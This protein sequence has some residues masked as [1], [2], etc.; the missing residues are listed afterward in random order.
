MPEAAPRKTVLPDHAIVLVFLRAG[1]GLR[2]AELCRAARVFP[3]EVNEYERGHRTLT[4]ERLNRL[5]DA[6]GLPPE[7]V[8]ASLEC[9]AGNRAAS[10]PP[11]DSP[12]TSATLRREIEAVATRAGRLEKDHVRAL[13]TLLAV[14]DNGLAAH[15]HAPP[16]EPQAARR[17]TVL[18]D[19]AI[20]LVFLRTGKGWSQ[21]EL[22]RAAQLF[23]S[24]ISEYESGSRTLIRERLDHLAGA[25]GLPPE[26]VDE[27]LDCLAVNR[28]LS[29]PTESPPGP[30]AALRRRIEALAT[31]AGRLEKDHVRARSIY[32]TVQAEALVA[33]QHAELRMARLRTSTAAQRRLLVE[34]DA[35]SR[36]WAL[37]EAAALESV[38]LAP[39]HPLQ[40]REWAEW[41][42]RIAELVPGEEPCRWR[43]Q[44][45]TLHFLSNALRACNDLPAAESAL[46]RGRP[47]WE[48][49][50]PG[51]PGMI[52]NAAWPPWIEANL[53]RDQRRFP[54]ALQ[55][56]DE[57][58][59]LDKGELIQYPPA[60]G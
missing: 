20:V 40:A 46:A 53:R 30:R 49:G 31:K 9:L 32:L 12:G 21:M 33:R 11:G 44:G 57:A 18:P 39:N 41:A 47:L 59:A 3:S 16:P 54:E 10:A 42:V 60:D 52:L 23:P 29:S 22:C 45:W 5:A 38:R 4:R 14:Q 26:R 6:M 35:D 24:E 34:T 43:L 2:Q 28:A 48:A 7:R 51:D 50:A 58:L 27:S 55:R 37:A 56:I 17:K 36:S 13:L 8:D 15:R 1:Q 19:H 25:M